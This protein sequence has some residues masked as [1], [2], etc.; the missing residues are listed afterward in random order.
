MGPNVLAPVPYPS[1]L[2]NQKRRISASKV[3]SCM[4]RS[5]L[6]KADGT[7]SPEKTK[8]NRGALVITFHRTRSTPKIAAPAH[9]SGAIQE[10]ALACWGSHGANG[11]AAFAHRDVNNGGVAR[12]GRALVAE[13]GTAVSIFTP[14][15]MV[16]S[17]R[18]PRSSNTVV[19][20]WFQTR[21]TW[22][23]VVCSPA[24]RDEREPQPAAVG[25]PD[26]PVWT[27][28]CCLVEANLPHAAGYTPSRLALCLSR[29]AAETAFGRGAR[30]RRIYETL[31]RNEQRPD[32]ERGEGRGGEEHPP[33]PP[34]SPPPP[35]PP[36]QAQARSRQG[37]L[38][39][40]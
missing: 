8:A 31:K 4:L 1:G 6:D 19:K 10:P 35:S 15:E 20:Y 7:T 16:V 13:W 18:A 12:C 27:T 23:A 33:P 26:P 5:P 22:G 36:P 37:P 3:Q 32:Q 30:H 9:G 29:R 2:Q 34:S 39:P 40:R 17:A 24:A 28:S 38:R 21:G 11:R 25:L 14:P